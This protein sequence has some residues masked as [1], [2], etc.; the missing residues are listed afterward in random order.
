M[1][2][3]KLL[4]DVKIELTTRSDNTHTHSGIGGD[5]TEL[6]FVLTHSLVAKKSADNKTSYEVA[7]GNIVV[8]VSENT[9]LKDLRLSLKEFISTHPDKLEVTQDQM[10]DLE[11][12]KNLKNQSKDLTTLINT[13]EVC[14]K[15]T[16]SSYTDSDIAEFDN[17]MGDIP[18]YVVYFASR[19]II[20]LNTM[21]KYNLDEK[22]K[23]LSTLASSY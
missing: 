10:K 12:L 1:N 23:V 6:L 19:V 22:S 15:L 17:S 11:F 8:N 20:N 14:Q 21:V 3:D 4:N 16:N 9:S 7:D 18:N 13:I 2:I 5:P